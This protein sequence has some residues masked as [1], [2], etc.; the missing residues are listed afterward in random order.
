MTLSF[1]Q[2]L[3]KNV[4]QVYQS[5]VELPCW[6]IPSFSLSQGGVVSI[7]KSVGDEILFLAKAQLKIYVYLN[8]KDLRAIINILKL[9]AQQHSTF[10]RNISEKPFSPSEDVSWPATNPLREL[11]ASYIKVLG[12]SRKSL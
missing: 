10:D 1:Q 4:F 6:G 2:Y 12:V 3:Q 7:K 8:C 11:E 5:V 9:H